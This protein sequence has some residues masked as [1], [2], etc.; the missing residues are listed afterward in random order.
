MKGK[1]GAFYFI[2]I[3]TVLKLSTTRYIITDVCT[4]YNIILLFHFRS[5]IF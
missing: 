1:D 2:Y 3:D 5:N 4:I